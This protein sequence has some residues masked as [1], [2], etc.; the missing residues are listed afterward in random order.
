MTRPVA[1]T[2][3]AAISVS[4]PVRRQTRVFAPISSSGQIDGPD[5]QVTTGTGAEEEAP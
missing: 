3:P 1:V 5:A 2:F 4:R